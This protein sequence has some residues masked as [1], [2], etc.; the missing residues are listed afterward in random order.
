MKPAS[1][2]GVWA[3]TASVPVRFARSAR[4]LVLFLVIIPAALHAAVNVYPTEVFV[5]PPNRSA[6]VT[7]KNPS[8]REVEVW[9]TFAYEYPVAF[10]S[11]GIRMES[12]D[13]TSLDEPNAVKWLRAI[14]QRFTLRPQESQ[15]VRIYGTPPPGLRS[16]EYW[17]RVVVSS[18]ELKPA[19]PL[20]DQGGMKIGMTIIT[21]TVVPFHFRVGATTSNVTIRDANISGVGKGVHVRVLLDR[22]GNAAYWGRLTTKIL[23]PGGKVI[24]TKESRIVVYK[25]MDY[26]TDV[27]LSGELTGSY[28]VELTVDNHHPSLSPEFRI[29]G[30]SVTQRYSVLLQ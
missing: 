24:R 4:I 19:T 27:D 21:N 29:P 5:K 11:S 15:V 25:T 22:Q 3:A 23:S 2:A 7:V 9:L 18:K 26:S 28:T 10:D 6:P 13:S 1:I 20:Q 17:A 14:P 30:R 8:D 12:G 16:G